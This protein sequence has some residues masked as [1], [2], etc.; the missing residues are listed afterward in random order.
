VGKTFESIPEGKLKDEMRALGLDKWP[1][2]QFAEWYEVS[3]RGRTSVEVFEVLLDQ[4]QVGEDAGD[5]AVQ[6]G[7]EEGAECG[8]VSEDRGEPV[9]VVCKEQE[10]GGEHDHRGGCAG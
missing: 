9:R 1:E 4:G 7:A 8:V 2:G 5:R 3:G 10:D 6:A